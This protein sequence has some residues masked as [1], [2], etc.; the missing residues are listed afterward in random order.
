[1]IDDSSYGYIW[2][3]AKCSCHFSNIIKVEGAIK[4]EKKCP[5]CKSLNILGLT[6]DE[7]SIICHIAQK[8]F[9]ANQEEIID[10]GQFRE[11]NS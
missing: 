10:N 4:Q 2:R 8:N 9:E 5:K 1:M 11:I 3:C 6:D 7:I